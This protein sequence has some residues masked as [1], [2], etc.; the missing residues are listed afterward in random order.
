VK[1]TLLESPVALATENNEEGGG[2]EASPSPLDELQL[3]PMEEENEEDI[4]EDEKELLAIR[5]EAEFQRMRQK[6]LM[7]NV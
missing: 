5:K 1:I 4:D 3:A 7:G 6:A 2:G